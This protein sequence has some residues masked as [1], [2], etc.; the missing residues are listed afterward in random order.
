MAERLDL[1]ARQRTADEGPQDGWQYGD[2]LERQHAILMFRVAIAVPVK[3]L[4]WG[5]ELCGEYFVEAMAFTYPAD[6]G[7]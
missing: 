7:L 6:V 1:A 4:I 5:N 3:V 2:I